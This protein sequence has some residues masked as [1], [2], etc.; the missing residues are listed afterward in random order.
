MKGPIGA[1]L[2][3]FRSERRLSDP[4]TAKTRAGAGKTSLA[5]LDEF[6]LTA[7]IERLLPHSTCS[8]CGSDPDRAQILLAGRSVPDGAARW[9]SD[10]W[11]AT[12]LVGLREKNL[13]AEMQDL[14]VLFGKA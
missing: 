7:S 4:V 6:L 11:L 10:G 13:V 1:R 14:L 5:R 3:A 9:A 8:E 2:P 12:C